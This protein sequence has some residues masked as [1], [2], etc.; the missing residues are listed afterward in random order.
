MWLVIRKPCHQ[1]SKSNGFHKLWGEKLSAKKAML[2]DL[3]LCVGCNVCQSACKEENQLPPSEEKY[4]SLTAYTALSKYNDLYIRRMCQHCDVPTCVSVC[5][6]AA[7]SKADEGPVAYDGE[8]CIGCRYCLQACPYHVPKYEW[9]S[10]KPRI[11][12]CKF[13][14]PR[15]AKGLPPACAEACP[16]GATIFGERDELLLEAAR[17]VSAE[18]AKYVPRIYGKDD[19]G[20]TSMLYL[21]P[22]PFE[23][24]GFDSRLGKIP[25]PML[26]M[27]ALSKVPNVLSV[28]GVMLGGIWWITNRRSEVAAFE[29]SEKK[30]E[31]PRPE[32]KP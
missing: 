29:A 9:S 17:R 12:K 16:T 30:G 6:V 2:I 19:V 26:T 24:L 10:T 13:C 5:P 22:V 7:L 3:T 11:Q 31:S 20:G 28:G 18:P 25:M 8:K 4:L 27:S 23:Q 21:S 14:A 1:P 32:D 15:L